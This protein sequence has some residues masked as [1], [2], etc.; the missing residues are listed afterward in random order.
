MN[1]QETYIWGMQTIGLMKP[2]YRVWVTFPHDYGEHEK[3]YYTFLTLSPVGDE[4]TVDF[5]KTLIESEEIGLD[6]VPDY[7]S[8][9]LSSTDYV[10]HM[11]VVQAWNQKT[12]F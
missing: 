2:I 9:S 7:L 8:V 12:I 3:Y 1:E 10:G 6:E 11:F 4:L 5:A